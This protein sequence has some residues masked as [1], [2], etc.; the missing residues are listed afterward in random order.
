MVSA[1]S[2]H[3]SRQ[4][5]YGSLRGRAWSAARS[6]ASAHWSKCSCWGKCAGSGVGVHRRVA[7]G[8]RDR[9]PRVLYHSAERLVETSVVS[10]HDR[11]QV[12]EHEK[13]AARQSGVFARPSSEAQCE[14][15][16][17][18]RVAVWC[19]SGCATS[20]KSTSCTRI[21]HKRSPGRSWQARASHAATAERRAG[22]PVVSTGSLWRKRLD[23]WRRAVAVRRL[24]QRCE[25][26]IALQRAPPRARCAF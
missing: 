15:G 26:S 21:G 11:R 7:S 25:T 1:R 6:D 20:R 24:R 3:S 8:Q 14:Y 4:A 12:G 5:R 13:I 22:P 19:R 2:T 18:R 23:R 17:A 10:P 16:V 9:A